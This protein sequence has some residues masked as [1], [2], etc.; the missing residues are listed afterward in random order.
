MTR[1]GR[2]R[3]T[4]SVAVCAFALIGGLGENR[5]LAGNGVPVRKVGAVT[6]H[7]RQYVGQ[8]VTLTGYLLALETGYVLFSDEPTGKIS[9]HD[10]PVT[11]VGLDLLQ[12]MRKYLIEGTFLDHGL[13]ASNGNRYHLELTGV[14]VDTNAK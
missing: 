9:A 1:Q 3:R 14:P 12:P 5:V 13:E 10:L 2:F 7:A 6:W 11:G 8:H 4:V